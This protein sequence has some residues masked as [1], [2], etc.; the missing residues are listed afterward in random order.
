MQDLTYLTAVAIVVLGAVFGTG[1]GC[2]GLDVGAVVALAVAADGLKVRFV[3]FG[4][5]ADIL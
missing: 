4:T 5:T 1:V 3:P 2:V